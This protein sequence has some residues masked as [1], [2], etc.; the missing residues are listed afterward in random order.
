[1]KTKKYKE[2]EL[3][4]NNID[5]IVVVSANHDEQQILEIAKKQFLSLD[6]CN[7]DFKEM[8]KGN[9]ANIVVN[10]KYVP[11]YNVECMVNDDYHITFKEEGI[12]TVHVVCG[13]DETRIDQE[14]IS[15]LCKEEVVRFEGDY[16]FCSTDFK[17]PF[18]NRLV[19]LDLKS[20]R[21]KEDGLED[22]EIIDRFISNKTLNKLIND[23]VLQAFSGQ[24]NNQAKKYIA[25]RHN[26]SQ[27]LDCK[28][29][30]KI[31]D[32]KKTLYLVPLYEVVSTFAEE[33]YI[34]YIAGIDS[35]NEYDFPRG[36]AFIEFNKKT[37]LNHFIRHILI[38][39]MFVLLGASC[40]FGAL[41]AYEKIEKFSKIYLIISSVSLSIICLLFLILY[42]W[43][44]KNYYKKKDI[45]LTKYEGSAKK[46]KSLYLISLIVYGIIDLSCLA[47]IIY[48]LIK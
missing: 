23:K 41:L 27:L 12:A 21:I 1:M 39:L 48:S 38:S 4:F 42:T 26:D 24:G 25:S 20:L 9:L 5:N 47:F 2:C 46:P 37:R 3:E 18:A 7:A 19:H 14:T 28:Q 8:I 16:H 43:K 11:L 13:K 30:T 45:I 44:S 31:I 34:S 29:N 40:V 35:M 6:S 36:K 17:G 32:T 22:I 33:E 15:N 10:K